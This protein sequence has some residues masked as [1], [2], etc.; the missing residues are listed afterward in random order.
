[1]V[2]ELQPPVAE[3]N[4]VSVQVSDSE[5]SPLARAFEWGAAVSLN[6]DPRRPGIVSGENYCV[7]SP[8]QQR[9]VT[10]RCGYECE[11]TLRP[12]F[13]HRPGHHGAG[14][15]CGA[16]VLAPPHPGVGYGYGYLECPSVMAGG[17]D[18]NKLVMG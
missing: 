6:E 5:D 10:G 14:Y 17:T 18:F 16:A 2:V 4:L 7:C 13:R 9:S 3:L 12:R 11:R 15:A 8:S 1:V